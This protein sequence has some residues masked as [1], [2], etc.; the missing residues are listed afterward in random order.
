M[1]NIAFGEIVPPLRKI[2]H[3]I[4]VF[5]EREE[6]V[7]GIGI[8]VA[9]HLSMVIFQLMESGKKLGYF[10]KVWLWHF[11]DVYPFNIFQHQGDATVIIQ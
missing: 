10:S 5:P 6:I 11:A 3:E 2:Q 8:I 7:P 9:D 1:D 4:A